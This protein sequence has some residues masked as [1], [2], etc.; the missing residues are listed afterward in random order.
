MSVVGRVVPCRECGAGQ[1]Y[2]TPNPQRNLVYSHQ[3]GSARISSS[4]IPQ[5]TREATFAFLSRRPVWDGPAVCHQAEMTGTVSGKDDSHMIAQVT[6]RGL[7]CLGDGPPN[8][9]IRAEYTPRC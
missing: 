6:R 4:G 8:L 1:L 5:Q 7:R 9:A 2:H 3:A